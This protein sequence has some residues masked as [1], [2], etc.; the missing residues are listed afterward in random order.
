[1]LDWRWPA[2]LFGA[3]SCHT[4]E[5][6]R[7]LEAE[8]GFYL[9]E[10]P[11]DRAEPLYRCQDIL[12]LHAENSPLALQHIIHILEKLLTDLPPDHLTLH[13]HTVQTQSLQ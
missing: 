13:K 5:V 4:N 1:M 2:I 9:F 11:F 6:V 7:R 3:S 10:M 8:G 12:V